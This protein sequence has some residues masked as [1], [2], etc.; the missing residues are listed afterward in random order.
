MKSTYAVALVNALAD[1]LTSGGGGTEYNAMMTD[2]GE[3]DT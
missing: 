2:I 1:G 3:W